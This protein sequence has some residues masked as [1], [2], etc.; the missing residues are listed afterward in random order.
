M[1]RL[2]DMTEFWNRWK[3]YFEA[4][5]GWALAGNATWHPWLF[6]RAQRRSIPAPL[7]LETSVAIWKHHV[8]K[9][10]QTFRRLPLKTEN[11]CE[12]QVDIKDHH[13]GKS[14]KHKPH[15]GDPQEID[16]ANH[17]KEHQLAMETSTSELKK[18]FFSLFVKCSHVT[19]S[20][21]WSCATISIGSK[22]LTCCQ[23]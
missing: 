21:G 4:T 16:R 6:K 20:E 3:C 12:H 17:A 11:S 9:G 5:K 10:K 1:A 13:V 19:L 18:C 14:W 2:A 23:S 22:Y 8:A 15:D 7:V